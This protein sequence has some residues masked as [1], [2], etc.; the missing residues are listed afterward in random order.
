MTEKISAGRREFSGP[1]TWKHVG[2]CSVNGP[3]E[4][5]GEIRVQ[6]EGSGP[7]SRVD[8]TVSLE[9]VQ[10]TYSGHFSE[11]H[12]QASWIART[13]KGSHSRFRSGDQRYQRSPATSLIVPASSLVSGTFIRI[14]ILRTI[15]K[16]IAI[17]VN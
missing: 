9:S 13:P 15:T 11:R 17:N 6:I 8:A 10:C 5:R 3:E 14:I 2:L 7:A 12:Q 4:K 16:T 1:V